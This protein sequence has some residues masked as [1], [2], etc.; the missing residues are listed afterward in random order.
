LHAANDN[1]VVGSSAIT[2]WDLNL[3]IALAPGFE[4]A[5]DDIITRIDCHY[6]KLD[7]VWYIYKHIEYKLPN[8]LEVDYLLTVDQNGST[9]PPASYGNKAGVPY[10]G[11]EPIREYMVR[12]FYQ[13]LTSNGSPFFLNPTPFAQF[14]IPANSMVLGNWGIEMR[15][16]LVTSHL[17]NNGEWFIW[18]DFD[19]GATDGS[20]GSYFFLG[21]N[22]Y[23]ALVWNGLIRFQINSG[24]VYTEITVGAGPVSVGNGPNKTVDT[25]IN[26]MIYRPASEYGDTFTGVAP[27]NVANN[28]KFMLGYSDGVLTGRGATLKGVVKLR[29][30][31]VP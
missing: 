7:G 13:V 31:N 24:L 6:K 2:T 22:I 25:P 20:T 12:D 30:S 18:M 3:K 15:L 5:F 8:S 29:K 16:E 10:F 9:L 19:G 4:T 26:G 27:L 14:P 11:E 17:Q 28:L 1:S 21:G 23:G